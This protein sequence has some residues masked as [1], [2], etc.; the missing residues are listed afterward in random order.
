MVSMEMQG[1]SPLRQVLEKGSLV[2]LVLIA[3]AELGPRDAAGNRHYA[4]PADPR[5]EPGPRCAGYVS[6][7][8]DQGV[9]LVSGVGANQDLPGLSVGLGAIY[10]VNMVLHR[11]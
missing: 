3:N 10:R 5:N 6:K 2:E 11:E 7:V 1:D 8:D 9:T 4:V